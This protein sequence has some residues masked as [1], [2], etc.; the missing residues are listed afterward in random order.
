VKRLEQL[1][2]RNGAPFDRVV[3]IGEETSAASGSSPVST[4]LM[5]RSSERLR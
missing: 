1:A 5:P 3:L 4:R 2:E